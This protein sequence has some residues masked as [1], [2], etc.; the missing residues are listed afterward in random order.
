[1]GLRKKRTAPRATVPALLTQQNFVP[2]FQT[3]PSD[4]DPTLFYIEIGLSG[5]LV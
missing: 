5:S 1:M 3:Q 4:S 2:H